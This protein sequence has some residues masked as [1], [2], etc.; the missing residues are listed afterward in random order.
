MK[1]FKNGKNNKKQQADYPTV[2]AN[3]GILKKTA[4]S[5]PFTV[6]KTTLRNYLLIVLGCGFL[7]L[8]S[9]EA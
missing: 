5:L 3:G 4:E 7:V 6:I 8:S 2:T 9:G 1:Y